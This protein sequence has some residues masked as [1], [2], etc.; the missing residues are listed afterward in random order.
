MCGNE[1]HLSLMV[2]LMENGSY[3]TVNLCG[4][5]TQPLGNAVG[6]IMENGAVV[7]W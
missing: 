6:S 3:S 5:E 2:G 7:R 1:A 4:N